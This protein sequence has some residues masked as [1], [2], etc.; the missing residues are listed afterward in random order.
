M[1]FEANQKSTSKRIWNIF[2]F[3]VVISAVQWIK[4]RI[5]LKF[6]SFFLLKSLECRLFQLD[7]EI[8]GMISIDHSVRRDC[9]I[10]SSA[11]RCAV[12]TYCPV[13]GTQDRLSFVAA[14]YDHGDW[15][16]WQK[17]NPDPL[18]MWRKINSRL[19]S[20]ENG[21]QFECAFLQWNDWTWIIV[22][23]NCLIKKI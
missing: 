21:A 16:N 22:G 8:G 11:Q 12:T 7:S 18:W 1:N 9:S 20:N 2:Y 5:L 10:K 14:M 23:M 13:C 17:I 19:L 3:L 4:R 15:T 6:N